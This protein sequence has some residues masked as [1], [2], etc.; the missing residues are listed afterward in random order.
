M[1]KIHADR[2]ARA[3]AGSATQLRGWR[4]ARDWFA[5]AVP[6]F[7]TL[8][9]QVNLDAPDRSAMDDAIAGLAKSK[10]ELARLEGTIPR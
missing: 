9:K 1:G 8:S 2:A 5:R 3:P 4:T 7:E 10:T 6:K